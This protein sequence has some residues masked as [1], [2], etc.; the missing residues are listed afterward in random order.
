[1]VRLV[2]VVRVVEESFL[3]VLLDEGGSGRRF[4]D[5]TARAA[6][7]N[8][9]SAEDAAKDAEEDVENDA[10]D[11][12]LFDSA[13][14]SVCS[15]TALALVSGDYLGLTIDK[16]PCHTCVRDATVPIVVYTSIVA[17]A[18]LLIVP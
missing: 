3:V 2:L 15:A 8:G 7:A 9:D 5:S 18:I 4:G 13:T 10:S 17:V 14:S 12:T 11:L 1:M 16:A 6:H